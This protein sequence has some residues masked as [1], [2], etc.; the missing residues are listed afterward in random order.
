MSQ[1]FSDTARK[2]SATTTRHFTNLH[3]QHEVLDRNISGASSDH[4]QQANMI[5][6]IRCFSCGK[7]ESPPPQPSPP[8]LLTNTPS[9]VIADLYEKYVQL[10]STPQPGTDGDLMPDG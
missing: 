2:P 1:N 4:S 3:H 7:V 8:E 5:I 6:P 9:Q 10:I